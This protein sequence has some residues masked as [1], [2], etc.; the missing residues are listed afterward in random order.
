MLPGLTPQR[1]CR[2]FV[3]VAIGAEGECGHRGAASFSGMI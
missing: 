2:V 3:I 1:D